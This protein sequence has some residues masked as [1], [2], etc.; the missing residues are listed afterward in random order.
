MSNK[1]TGL[2]VVEKSKDT[3]A[4]VPPLERG[5][6]G[7]SQTQMNT[8]ALSQRRQIIRYNP[9]LKE[10]ARN[11]RNN[12]T[13]SEIILWSKLKGKFVGKYDFHRQKPIDNYIADFFCHEL[14]LVIELDGISHNSDEIIEKDYAKEVRLNELGL[15]VLRFK[16]SMVFNNLDGVLEVIRQYIDGF[17]RADLL[18]FAC[19]DTPLNPLSRGDLSGKRSI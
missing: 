19:E 7:V 2:A 6:G 12:S 15:N 8:T 16:D 13:K 17:E 1:T 4:I 9:K 14:A 5:L 11:L 3:A 10:L 18:G